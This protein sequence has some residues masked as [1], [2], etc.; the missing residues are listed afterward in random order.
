MQLLD[1]GILLAHTSGNIL[2]KQFSS[3]VSYLLKNDNTYVSDADIESHRELKRLLSYH[4]P[5]H[6]ILSEEDDFLGSSTKHA[7][8][9]LWV[10]DP[11]DGTSN[12]IHN[13]AY[14]CV[15]L[16]CIKLAGDG[17]YE[18]LIGVT[19]NPMTSELYYAKKGQGAFKEVLTD[20]GL[21]SRPEPVRLSLLKPRE[22][23]GSFMACGF[24][25]DHLEGNFEKKYISLIKQCDSSRRLGA[26]AL[27]LART[28]EGI[29]HVF[30]DANVKIWDYV[31]GALFIEEVGGVCYTFPKGKSAVTKNPRHMGI[32]ASGIICGSPEVTEK[33]CEHFYESH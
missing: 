21:A 10:L 28:A 22:L 16:S 4:C 31:A 12:F 17:T 14:F 3:G 29:F 25:G 9:Y 15:T 33:V 8:R 23:G 6:D 11:L 2:K 20:L 13:L 7:A 5:D 19:Y 18:P 24:H 27:D 32:H 30:F 1:L 26:A